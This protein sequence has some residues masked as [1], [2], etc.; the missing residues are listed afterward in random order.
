MNTAPQSGKVDADCAPFEWGV[1]MVLMTASAYLHWVFMMHAGGL[2]RDEAVSFGIATKPSV[3]EAFG[4]LGIESFPALFHAVLRLWVGMGFAQTDFGIRIFG[5]LVGLSLLAAFWISGRLLGCRIPFFSLVLICL[6]PL[7]I[8]TGDCIRAYGVGATFIV[9]ALGLVWYLLE[10]PS[11][12]RFLLAAIAGIFSVQSLY[13]NSFLL[14][15]ICLGG[16][17]IAARRR[18]WNHLVAILGVG[19]ISAVSL[20]L[21]TGTILRMREYSRVIVAEATFGRVVQ[22]LS[23]A[24]SDGGSLMLWIWLGLIAGGIVIAMRRQSPFFQPLPTLNEQDL[25]LFLVVTLITA[26]CGFGVWIRI[27]DFPTQP[28]YYIPPMALVA[29]LLD[30]IYATLPPNAT[31]RTARL[32]CVC[33]MGMAVFY[34][35]IPGVKIRQTNVDIVSAKVAAAVGKGDLILVRPWYCGTTFNRYFHLDTAWATLPPLED[36]S[37]QRLDLF[38]DAMKRED[39]I[40]PVIDKIA[41]TLKSGNRVWLVGGLPFLQEGQSPPV[42]S[43]APDSKWGWDHDAYSAIWELQAAHFI[44]ANALRAEQVEVPIDLAVNPFENLPL[45]VVEGWRGAV[46]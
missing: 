41:E 44:Q 31:W 45:V 3:E 18:L 35:A 15:A 42:I 20:L 4:F 32:A 6:S 1:A 43:P 24:L 26:V 5:G 9:L 13:Q 2:W 39:P 21:Y 12:D 27:L 25:R 40:A 11:K 16:M 10:K 33:V 36:Q 38:V 30:A 37:L 34:Y 7:A 23:L 22:M 19:L 46:P 8:R 17:G 14:L 28:W 29:V